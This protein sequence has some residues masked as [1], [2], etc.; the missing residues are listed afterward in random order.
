MVLFIVRR[1][2]AMAGVLLALTVVL[3]ALQEASGVDPAK[4]YV[5]ANASQEAVDAARQ[6]LGLDEPFMSRYVNYLSGLFH[7]DLQN[8]LRTRTPVA[9]DVGDALPASLELGACVLFV[10]VLLG[11]GFAY[12][13]AI[14]GRGAA[15]LRTVLFSGAAAPTFLLGMIALIVFYGD[16]GWLPSG[17]RSGFPDAPT[18]PTGFLLIDS[19]LAVRFDVL[20]DALAHLVLPVLCAAVAPAVAIGRVL[21]DGLSVNLEADHARTARA[22]GLS[23]R[24]V[25]L[26]HAIRN[27][28]GPTLSMI[29]IQ[30]GALLAGLVVVEKIFAWPGVGSYLDKSVAASDLPG[31]TGVAL[32]MGL[33]YVFVNAVVDILQVAADR[34]IALT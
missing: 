31:I 21:A 23:E 6:R 14:R 33:V 29:G 19:L 30:A 26:R 4:A 7:G 1:T 27:S 12:A 34:R 20:S 24:A 11:T 3:F 16:L 25:L 13:S 2:A 10:A 8:S 9:Q 32:L 22:T 28:L 17:G 15:V 5:G 18:G